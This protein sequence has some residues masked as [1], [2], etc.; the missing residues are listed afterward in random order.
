MRGEFDRSAL[1]QLK[2]WMHHHVPERS[3]RRRA[4]DFLGIIQ[5]LDATFPG[6]ESRIRVKIRTGRLACFQPGVL[7]YT[8]RR[9][10]HS[11]Q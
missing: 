1:Y 2:W 11:L 4:P 10:H 6:G 3:A 9:T 8:Y 7:I 5:M